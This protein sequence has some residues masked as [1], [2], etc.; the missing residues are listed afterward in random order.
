VDVL[1]EGLGRPQGLAFD[2]DGY[3][4]VVDALAGASGVFRLPIDRPAPPEQV[5]AGG[6]LIGLAF[7]PRGG[8]VVASSDTAYRLD[9]PLRGLLGGLGIRD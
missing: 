2:A 5:L 9:V 1:Y 4:Y 7:D 3:L 6:S 8:L